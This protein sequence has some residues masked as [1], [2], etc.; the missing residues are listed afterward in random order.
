LK[1]ACILMKRPKLAEY[2]SSEFS[3]DLFKRNDRQYTVLGGVI[4]TMKA[5]QF[6]VEAAQNWINQAGYQPELQLIEQYPLPDD[7]KFLEVEFEAVVLALAK[8]MDGDSLGHSGWDATEMLKL[9]EFVKNS[10]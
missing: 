10:N 6:I 3:E 9:Q 8:A 2:F 1:L 4:E 7:D 5:N